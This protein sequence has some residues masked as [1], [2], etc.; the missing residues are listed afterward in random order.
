MKSWNMSIL[1]FWTMANKNEP[2]RGL[3]GEGVK[4]SFPAKQ[5]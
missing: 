3:G 2:K 5:Q 4:L 1:L